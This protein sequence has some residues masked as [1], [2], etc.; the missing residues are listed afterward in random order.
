MF[1][2]KNIAIALFGESHGKCVG[3]SLEGFPPGVKIDEGAIE[4]F[5]K[6]R[7]P[8]LD[9]LSTQ[10]KESDIAEILSGVSNGITTGANIAFIINNA[11]TRSEDYVGLECA[12]PSHSDY[13]ANIRY[14]G[15]N[16]P[17]GS[18]TF[19]GR[20]TAPIVFIGALCSQLLKEH[21]VE[22]GAHIKSIGSVCDDSFDYCNIDK[23]TLRA[24]KTKEFPTLSE[25]SAELMTREILKAK[26]NGDSIGGSIECCAIN[27]KPGLGGPYFERVQSGIASLIFSIPAFYGL[28]FGNGILMSSLLGSE[29]NDQI[30]AD[31]HGAFKTYTNNC[32]GIN[33]GITNSMPIVFKVFIKPTPSI[34]KKQ[35]SI[36]IEQLKNKE[37]EIKGRHD[38]CVARRAAVVVESVLAIALLDLYL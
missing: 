36:D 22:L 6:R 33:G 23:N 34:A 5:M 29:A 21:G 25:K 18:G 11:D 1:R 14:S 8:G 2:G 3:A 17:K 38:P 10:R 27:V 4:G 13:T 9:K 28:E 26:E 7:R 20:L 15:F 31:E 32:G 12:R 30:Y 35:K 37:F 24:L 16:D 19:S